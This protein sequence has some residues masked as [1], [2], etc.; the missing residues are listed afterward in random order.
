MVNYHFDQHPKAHVVFVARF[1]PELKERLVECSL[2]FD[3]SQT[4]L[5][6][7]ALREFF[8][9]HPLPTDKAVVG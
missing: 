5:V 2:A 3:E 9:Q 7:T 6:T 1:T 4:A 8:R